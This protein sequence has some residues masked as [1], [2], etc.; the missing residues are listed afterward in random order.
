M[1]AAVDPKWPFHFSEIL[2][3]GNPESNFAVCTLWTLRDKFLPLPDYAIIGNMYYN[4]GINYLLRGILSNPNIRYLVLCGVDISKSGE[5]LVKLFKDGI[6]ENHVIIGTGVQLEKE[7]P[8]DAIEDVRKHVFLIDMRNILDKDAVKK[9]IKEQEPLDA[10]A[11]ARVFPLPEMKPV[12]TFPSEE[13][14]FIIRDS[15]VADAWLRIVRHVMRFG[16]IKKT[17]QSSDMRELVNLVAIID[18][19]NPSDPYTPEFLPFGTT[20]IENYYPQV[21]TAKGVEGTKYTYGQD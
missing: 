17:Q 1:K 8:K 9:K 3:K 21:M 10:F 11:P 19:E 15:K 5:A 20:E 2:A 14:G 6:D 4:E 16:N 7:I 13:T 18:G 12:E